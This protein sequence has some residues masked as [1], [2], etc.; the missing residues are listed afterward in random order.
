MSPDPTYPDGWVGG[1]YVLL[2]FL[3]IYYLFNKIERLR[4]VGGDRYRIRKLILIDRIRGHF[5]ARELN[6]SR[7]H[8]KRFPA[9][10]L[11]LPF[12]KR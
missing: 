8:K 10:P 4:T 11:S 3:M 7:A 6:S 12:G 9:H 1:S 5:G 2:L